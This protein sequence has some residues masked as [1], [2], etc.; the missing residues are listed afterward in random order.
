[1]VELAYVSGERQNVCKLKKCDN[2]FKSA[3]YL[4]L[5]DIPCDISNI[6]IF[7]LTF[8]CIL[9]VIFQDLK[10]DL[11]RAEVCGSR[12]I[13][14]KSTMMLLTTCKVNCIVFC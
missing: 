10:N 4:Y 5:I 3:Q 12:A 6:L 13:L 14:E 1:M 7:Q 9:L 2:L 8:K 11:Q